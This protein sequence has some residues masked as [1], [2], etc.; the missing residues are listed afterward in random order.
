MGNI[1]FNQL[2]RMDT[3][4]YL[5]VY[6]QVGRAGLAVLAGSA[7]PDVPGWLLS[8]LSSGALLTTLSAAQTAQVAPQQCGSWPTGW[9]CAVCAA[10]RA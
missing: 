8:F 7:R 1:A 5:L 6:P 4:L 2:S 10:L 3:L 9:R